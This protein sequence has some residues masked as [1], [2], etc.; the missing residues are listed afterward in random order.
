MP[1]RIAL[2][3]QRLS[4]RLVSAD[5]RRC[6]AGGQR[7]RPAARGGDGP[8]EASAKAEVARRLGAEHV[9]AIGNGA[10]DASLLSAAR[11]GIAV[12]GPEGA[13]T[14]TLA[15]AD[16]AVTRVSD[17]L[18]LLLSDARLVATLRR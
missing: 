4:V 11:L 3:C 12:I 7:A 2:L 18:D 9:A 13:A 8:D 17:A 14:V 6:L 5:T 15:S 16:V 1:E 10:V